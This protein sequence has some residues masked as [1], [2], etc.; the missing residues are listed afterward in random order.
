MYYYALCKDGVTEFTE[1]STLDE[2]LAMLLQ[3]ANE[4]CGGAFGDL[5]DDM[6]KAIIDSREV[7]IDDDLS[8]SIVWA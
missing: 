3:L 6:E 8:A 7:T 1:V 4:H 5:D 2:G